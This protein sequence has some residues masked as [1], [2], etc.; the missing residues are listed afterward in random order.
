MET[1][2]VCV[3]ED[4]PALSEAVKIKLSKA[5]FSVLTAGT[6]EEAMEVLKN[7]KPDLVWLDILLPGM[8][9]LEVLRKIKSTSE[10]KDLKVVVVS[11][12]AGPEKIQEAFSL[13]AIDYLVKSEYTID[14]LINKVTEILNN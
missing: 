9:G 3:V 7:H 13:G 8:N 2:T 6:G 5:G 4:E 1:K 10:L 11:V 12:S 14:Q